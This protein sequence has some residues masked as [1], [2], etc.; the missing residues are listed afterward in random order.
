MLHKAPYQFR[1]LPS[2][3]QETDE[4]FHIR[5]TNELFKSYEEYISKAQLYTKE[6]WS[7]SLTGKSNL[8]L[9]EALEVEKAAR[10]RLTKFPRVL[11]KPTLLLAH[12]SQKNLDWMASTITNQYKNQCAVGEVVTVLAGADEK[13][14]LVV[15][16]FLEFVLHF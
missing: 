2:D 6:V 4:V 1:S 13:K 15:V 9:E 5:A 16:L 10:R 8:T 7:C 3:L 11:E 14:K 12:H